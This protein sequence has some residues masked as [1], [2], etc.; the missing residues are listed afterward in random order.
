VIESWG[1]GIEIIKV[2]VDE[3]WQV[4]EV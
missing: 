4:R 1:F 2:Y 3:N